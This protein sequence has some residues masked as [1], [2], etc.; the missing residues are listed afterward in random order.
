LTLESIIDVQRAA[1]C[2]LHVCGSP[3]LS[4]SLLLYC[5]GASYLHVAYINLHNS[6]R[7]GDD[8]RHYPH[9]RAATV[10][11]SSTSPHN[12][13]GTSC[14]CPKKNVPTA[15]SNPP[16]LVCPLDCILSMAA[17]VSG[18]SMNRMSSVAMASNLSC[19]SWGAT[20]RRK[21]AKSNAVISLLLRCSTFTEPKTPLLPSTRLR[22]PENERISTTDSTCPWKLLCHC[23]LD[24]MGACVC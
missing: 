7:R 8:H 9:H 4:L 20:P 12:T 21:R 5:H 24:K 13:C 6:A 23:V 17:N 1:D 22:L 19:C 3:F 15:A 10:A 18:A 16:P 11:S 14:L 2:R